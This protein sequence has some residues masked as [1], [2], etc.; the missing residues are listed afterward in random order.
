MGGS[1]T[2][3]ALVLRE[4]G[5]RPEVE[6]VELLPP[7]P[8]EVRIRVVA[9]GLCRSDLANA[10]GTL[11]T[12]LPLVL[13]HEAAGVVL[14]VGERV[15]E[16]AVGDRVVVSLSPACGQCPM[17]KDDKPHLC[18]QSV[19]GS[20]GCTMLDGTT[21]L[22]SGDE[23][24]HQL[25]AIGGFAE[26][27]V[28]NAACC[29]RVPDELPL[30]Q[31]CLL[32]CCVTTGAGAV[33]NTAALKAGQSVAIIGCGGVG[34]AAVQ[35]ARIAGAT[36]IV[37]VDVVEP[38]RKYALAM[39]ATHAVDGT[40]DDVAKQVKALCRFGPNVV[41]EA[42]GKSATIETAWRMVGPGGKVIVVG[43]PSARDSVELRVA[44]FFQACSIEGCVY[45]SA[46]PRR[47]IPRLLDL[48]SRGEFDLGAMITRQVP[49]EGAADALDALARSEGLRQVIVN[50]N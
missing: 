4:I 43:M 33:L 36:T 19:A 3:R 31:A 11:R 6:E 48:V 30:E 10:E 7:G 24:V 18:F 41:I 50:D 39:G 2:I 34:L 16:P 21:R 1:T 46:N 13:G 40:A 27:A 12:P 17:C 14:E 38:R 45:G 42:V 47:D 22:R 29:I 20:I 37:A 9:C 15:E 23:V 5:L 28:V 8:G 25:C 26:Q 35:A 32:G 44:G 49:L